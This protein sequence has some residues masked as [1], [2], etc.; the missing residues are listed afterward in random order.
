[1]QL[2]IPAN[3]IY[4][5]PLKADD[6]QAVY[7][8]VSN[9]KVLSRLDIPTPYDEGKARD[10]CCRAHVARYDWKGEQLP[11]VFAVRDSTKNGIV[12]GCIDLRLS[13]SASP[14]Y[15]INKHFHT[16]DGRSA[17]VGYWLALDYQGRG[18]MSQVVEA[19]FKYARDVMAVDF[20]CAACRSNN[21]ASA[22]TIVNAGL[23]LREEDGGVEYY[24][25]V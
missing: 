3:D 8:A 10:F 20:C 5:S 24:W 4:I 19:V 7:E 11:V 23:V 22:K 21:P 14:F 6:W 9:P 15:A 18:L 17:E 12:V 13:D 1:M 2:S 16:A 25:S